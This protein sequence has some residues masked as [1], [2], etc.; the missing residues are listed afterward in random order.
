MDIEK[1][2]EFGLD[3]L[4]TTSELADYL[5]VKVQ[6]IYDLRC[7]GGGPAAIHVGREL[8]YRTREVRGWLERMEDGTSTQDTAVLEEAGNR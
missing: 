5:G 2:V 6:A 1:A 4:L 8:R 3:P 7:H